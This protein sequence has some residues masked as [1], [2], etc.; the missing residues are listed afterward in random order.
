MKLKHLAT[1]LM[2]GAL[3]ALGIAIPANAGCLYV[4][5]GVGGTMSQDR[6]SSGGTID[7]S[8]SGVMAS[9]GLFC[10]VVGPVSGATGMFLDLGTRGTWQ[11]NSGDV[12]GL[13]LDSTYAAEALARLGYRWHEK[14]EAYG[15][16]GLQWS[17]L[18]LT[19]LGD[20]RPFAYEVGGGLR[21][22]VSGG[23]W[24]GAEIDYAMAQ[25]EDIAS[26]SA[27][28]EQNT[29]KGLLTLTYFFGEPLTQ[30]RP[31]K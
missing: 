15:Q 16:A 2:L 3:L 30:Q 28:L 17:D 1:S 29:L 24:L 10:R 13:T 11:H 27:K 4:E 6:L 21:G 23:W 22:H 26:G 20:K 25:K 14:V 31:L 18:K 9:L 7:L 12:S 5:G 8:Q 19:G